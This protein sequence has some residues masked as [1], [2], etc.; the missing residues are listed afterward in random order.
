[1]GS[2][3]GV[4]TFFDVETFSTIQEGFLTPYDLPHY[5]PNQIFNSLR[6]GGI[7][8]RNFLETQ[9]ELGK[10]NYVQLLHKREREE[11]LGRVALW[12]LMHGTSNKGWGSPFIVF[13]LSLLLIALGDFLSY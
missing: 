4:A 9:E 5:D 10:E 12:R 3:R 7:S 2:N 6:D 11:R 1:M 8:K 13:Q